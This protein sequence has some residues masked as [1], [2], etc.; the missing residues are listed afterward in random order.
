MSAHKHKT[1]QD[2]ID[3]H[4]HTESHKIPQ[5]QKMSHNTHDDTETQKTRERPKVDQEAALL[6]L[7]F[8]EASYRACH[9]ALS[10]VD[11]TVALSGHI[12]KC[13]LYTVHC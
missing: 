4:T 9:R 12:V 11:C 3:T 7:V 13:T 6:C 1:T 2:N 10:G 5:I 8:T